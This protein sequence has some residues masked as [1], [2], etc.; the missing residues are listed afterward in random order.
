MLGVCKDTRMTRE[1]ASFDVRRRA[2]YLGRQPQPCTQESLT[3]ERK[4]QIKRASLFD[5]QQKKG[6]R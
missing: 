6:L 5:M 3:S 4:R 2:L 1:T